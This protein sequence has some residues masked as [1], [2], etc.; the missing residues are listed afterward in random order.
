MGPLAASKALISL[1]PL[2]QVGNW[3]VPTHFGE[4]S[5]WRLSLLLRF[6]NHCT[7]RNRVVLLEGAVKMEK[8]L[9]QQI[10]DRAYELWNASGREHGRADEHWLS[11]EHE[12]LASVRARSSVPKAVPRSKRARSSLRP[13]TENAPTISR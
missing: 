4:E 10:R 11:A 6:V 9:E 8:S 5:D 1:L 7:I 3:E 12:L 13:R 2:Y